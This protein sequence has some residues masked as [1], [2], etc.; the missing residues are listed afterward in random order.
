M[1]DKMET[2][3]NKSVVLLN[4]VIQFPYLC[5]GKLHLM[6]LI[7]SFTMMNYVLINKSLLF[8]IL[9]QNVIH[10]TNILI[11]RLSDYF[12]NNTAVCQ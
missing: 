2:R 6:I 4:L 7:C 8:I 9:R 5:Y 11:R 1:L 3:I 10:V 12:I